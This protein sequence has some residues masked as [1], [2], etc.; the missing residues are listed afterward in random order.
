L[1]NPKCK[2]GSHMPDPFE[3][4]KRIYDAE[5][6]GLKQTNVAKDEDTHRDIGI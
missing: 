2:R 6:Y 5:A 3:S 1:R 4:R